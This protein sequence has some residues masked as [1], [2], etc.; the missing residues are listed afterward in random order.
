M[1]I[2]SSGSIVQQRYPLGSLEEGRKSANYAHINSVYGFSDR[3][4]LVCHNETK[5]TGKLSQIA[6]LDHSIEVRELIMTKARNAHHVGMY[7]GQTYC[8]DSLG[9]GL[10]CDG[11]T[12]FTTD[13]FTRGLSISDDGILLGGSEYAARSKRESASGAIFLLDHDFNL[14]Q[15]IQLPGM[16]QEIRRLDAV[17]YGLSNPGARQDA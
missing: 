12:V 15:M 5:K 4:Y 17:D 2:D 9:G 6:V 13:L 16:V 8:C 1:I 10:L 3:I 11:K 7:K 14:Q